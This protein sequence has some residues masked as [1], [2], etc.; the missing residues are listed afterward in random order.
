MTIFDYVVLFVLVCSAVIGTMRGLVREVV[1]L[2]S[3]IAAFMV[4][5]HYGEQMGQLL[6]HAIPGST[7]RLI[8]GFLILFIGVRLLMA[9]L[10][11]ALGSMI[12][13]GGLTGIDR[14]LGSL[15]GLV[16]GAVFVVALVLIC[17]MTA[18]PKQEFWRHAKLSALAE[19]GA[20]IVYPFLPGEM[21]RLIK[22]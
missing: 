4:A 7:V 11:M 6:P 2:L 10:A 1:S 17:G 21:A 8:A 5:N 14:G 3:W 13:A 15:F 9:L 16:R 18:L 19:S 12:E 20:R 22:F